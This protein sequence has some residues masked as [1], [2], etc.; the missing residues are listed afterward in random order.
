MRCEYWYIDFN[1]LFDIYIYIYII[2]SFLC[3]YI[4]QCDNEIFI[5]YASGSRDKNLREIE[6]LEKGNKELLLQLANHKP[7]KEL[8][9]EEHKLLNEVNFLMGLGD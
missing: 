7:L 9:E 6:E 1:S 2:F 3:K 4:S 8:Q 5:E